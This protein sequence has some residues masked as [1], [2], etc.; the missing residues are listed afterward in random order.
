MGGLGRFFITVT[1]D[2]AAM[3]PGTT[4][5]AASPV[6]SGGQTLG[7][8]ERKKVTNFAI[9]YIA[10]QAHDHGHSVRFAIA[11]VRTARAIR[12]DQ[13]WHGTLSISYPPTCPIFCVRSMA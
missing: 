6:G 2:I 10:T 12:Y 7:T 11:A 13:H 3:A 5:G 9:S 8:T 1:G 4:I